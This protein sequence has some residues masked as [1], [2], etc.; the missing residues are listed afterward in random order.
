MNNSYIIALW[1]ANGLANHHH[2]VQ[3]FLNL[4]KI[5][6]LLIFET[7]F[8]D[9]NYFKMAGYNTYETNH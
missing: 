8:T 1:N 3:A 6:I 7:H 5:D 9:K 2:E 4:N